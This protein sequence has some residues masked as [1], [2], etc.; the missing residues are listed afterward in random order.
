MI[1]KLIRRIIDWAEYGYSNNTIIPSL[2]GFANSRIRKNHLRQSPNGP[3]SS[4]DNNL[5]MDDG[6]TFT[7]YNADGGKVVKTSYYDNQNN[8]HTQSLHL[9]VAGESFA[10]QISIIMSKESMRR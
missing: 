3:V 7:I 8:R 4:P 1:K 10:E 2:N 5:D 9:I 6:F